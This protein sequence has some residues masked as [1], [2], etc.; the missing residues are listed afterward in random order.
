MR[1]K[2][3]YGGKAAGKGSTGFGLLAANLS[4][5]R[6]PRVRTVLGNCLGK[7]RHGNASK[8]TRLAGADEV[9]ARIFWGNQRGVRVEGRQTARWLGVN[10]QPFSGKILK[11]TPVIN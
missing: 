2:W 3:I 7:Y 10:E 11:Q 4:I 8:G 9:W 1:G 6:R 5:S